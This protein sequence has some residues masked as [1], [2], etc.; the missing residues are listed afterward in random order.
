M[1]NKLIAIVFLDIIID[2]LEKKL[3]VGRNS[4]PDAVLWTYESITSADILNKKFLLK[5]LEYKIEKT[6]VL[7]DETC[8]P[9][10]AALGLDE[11][12][13]VC[14]PI[15]CKYND[16]E[17]L[18]GSDPNKIISIVYWGCQVYAYDAQKDRVSPVRR[19]TNGKTYD[20]IDFLDIE[21]GIKMIN[22]PAGMVKYIEI[23]NP[24]Y[25]IQVDYDAL[26]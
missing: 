25:L 22:F 18:I 12:E 4:V 5:L 23:T 15:C 24:S 17:K 26:V 3:K 1:E 13:I 14:T 7:G 2:Y 21:K 10:N 6:E 20:P 8:E 16:N 9:A 11:C 19:T